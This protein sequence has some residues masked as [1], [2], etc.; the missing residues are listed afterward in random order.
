MDTITIDEFKILP[1]REPIPDDGKLY[2]M[3]AQA[4]QRQIAKGLVSGQAVFCL[5]ATVVPD[6]LSESDFSEFNFAVE[7]LLLE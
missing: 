1:E 2:Q 3:G 7:E 5:R 4:H 6:Y